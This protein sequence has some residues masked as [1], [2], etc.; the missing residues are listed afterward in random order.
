[1]NEYKN[2]SYSLGRNPDIFFLIIYMLFVCFGVVMVYSATNIFSFHKLKD[3]AYF[4]KREALWVFISAVFV[5]FFSQLN[6]RFLLRFSNLILIISIFLLLLVFVPF[7]GKEINNS[8]R[9]IGIGPFVF[10][11]S[12]FAKL[13]I[14]IFTSA[15]LSK[16]KEKQINILQFIRISAV[17]LFV[18]FLVLIEPDL[19]TSFVI[20]CLL[21][22]LL[23]IYGCKFVY[24][25]GLFLSIFPAFI[26]F[27]LI[28]PYVMSRLFAFLNP[29]KCAQKEGFQI[30]Q[31]MIA[32]ASGGVLGNGL[33]KSSQ[34]IFFLP[35]HYTDFIFSIIGEELGLLGAV[36]LIILFILFIVRGLKMAIYATDKFAKL[37]IVGIICKIAFQS[38]INMGVSLGIFPVTG[39]TLP[40]ISYGG[41]SLLILSIDIGI[42][43]NISQKIIIP[44]EIKYED[45]NSY[46][47][48]RRPY[49]PS[50][51]N[52]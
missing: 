15:Q 28:K 48:H 14:I 52:R 17:C 43:L 42:L 27:A 40:F 49:L 21:I 8:K 22:S 19:G 33:G 23:F 12:E 13:A 45:S 5:L 4:L 37:L 24:L 10:Q 9:W 29:W 1:M 34:K 6:Y 2:Y 44:H 31:S 51:Y 20:F 41:S 46:R 7:I 16:I 30:I 11:S 32:F 18:I 36:A 3:S 50:N 25:F 26:V 47:R 35:Y 38:F 39:V